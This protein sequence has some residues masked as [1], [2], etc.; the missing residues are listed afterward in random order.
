V[1]FL[2]EG[3]SDLSVRFGER[4]SII[5]QPINTVVAQWVATN[6]KTA[7]AGTDTL[8]NATALIVPLA[9]SLQVVGAL[10]VAPNDKDRFIDPEQV[11][12]L[13]TCGSLIALS[14]E[15]DRSMLQAHEAQLQI[16]AEQLRNS[17]L[18][19]VSHDLRTPLASIAGTASAL[20]ESVPAA[21]RDAVQTIVDESQRLTRLVENLLDM[22]RLDSG[23]VVLNRQWHVLEE[24]VGVALDSVKRELKQ[25][26]VRVAI[27]PDFPLLNIDGFLMEQVLVN[28]LENAS[29]YT[30]AGSEIEITAVAGEKRAEIRV[31]DNGPG[32]PPGSEERVF[33]KFFRGT[34]GAPDGRRGVGLGLAICQAIVVAHGGRITVTNRSRGGAIFTIDLPC[35]ET[36]PRVEAE[37]P[38]VTAT[39]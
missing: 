23:S 39:A 17:L 19:S 32:V 27:P 36:P 7:G 22:A 10:G 3:T 12:L 16:E 18:N 6:G 33:D 9:G 2:R 34:T 21:E 25:H 13:E 38:A 31:A 4:S 14:I 1:L 11:R 35:R 24:I 15:R 8:P 20:L 30:P 26:R 29:R 5:A 28:L 37:G